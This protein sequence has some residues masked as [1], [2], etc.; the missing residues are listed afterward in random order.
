[1]ATAEDKQYIVVGRISGLY[2]VRGWVKVYSHTQPR[3][4]ILNYS[5]WY[6]RQQGGWKALKLVDGKPHGK[7]IVARLEGYDDRDLSATLIQQDVAIL[8]EQLPAAAEDEY[9]WSDLIG[10]EVITLDG[11]SLGKVE[12]LLE[13]G[14]NDV[15][16]VQG[17]RER[18]IPYVPE[19]VIHQVDLAAQQI[20]VDWDPE[21]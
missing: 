4:N 14:S 17:E 19:Q 10:L 16:V 5:P 3:D 9:Y 12:H 1:M 11:V 21:F 6:L 15:L 7:G 2:G 20:S 13:T 18:L 8:R